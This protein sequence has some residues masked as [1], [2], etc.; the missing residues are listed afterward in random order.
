M[1]KILDKS[2]ILNRIKAHYKFKKDIDFAKFLGIASNT[3]GNWH[4]RN[5]MNFDRIFTK[6][7]ELNPNWIINGVGR[8]NK[9]YDNLEE[10]ITSEVGDVDQDYRL[11]NFGKETERLAKL[12]SLQ[13]ETIAAQAKTIAVMEKLIERDSALHAK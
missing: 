7:E 2:L 11:K 13:E 6:C 4:S 1:S 8:P 10:T 5:T 3:L 12:A 9:D